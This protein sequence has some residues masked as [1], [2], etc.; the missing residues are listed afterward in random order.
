MWILQ[1]A[2]VAMI[3]TFQ[4]N[5]DK[6]YSTCSLTFGVMF[7][8][9]FKDPFTGRFGKFNKGVDPL[10]GK[11]DFRRNLFY[12]HFV[13]GWEEMN[14]WKGQKVEDE[15]IVVLDVFSKHGKDRLIHDFVCSLING[16]QLL[17][18]K[19]NEIERIIWLIHVVDNELKG[20]G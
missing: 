3:Q 1:F 15:H 17:G 9:T 16:K 8:F 13:E 4:F 5:R 7:S 20:D 18:V 10:G 19:V 6:L 2:H 11:Y 12:A 14:V